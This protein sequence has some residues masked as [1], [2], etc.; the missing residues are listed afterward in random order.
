MDIDLSHREFINYLRMRTKVEIEKITSTRVYLENIPEDWAKHY[1]GNEI[2]NCFN[3]IKIYDSF[4]CT[5]SYEPLKVTLWEALQSRFSPSSIGHKILVIKC[6]RS[7]TGLGLKESKDITDANWDVWVSLP[8]CRMIDQ[9]APEDL[10][11]LMH[12]VKNELAQDYLAKKI[13]EAG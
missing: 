3:D 12:T 6:I 11:L 4:W 9:T 7:A 8:E 1:S 10:P 5:N 2:P 13:K